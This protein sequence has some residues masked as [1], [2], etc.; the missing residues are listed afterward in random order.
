M[1]HRPGSIPG[2]RTMDKMLNERWPGEASG[3][4]LSSA[5]GR[6]AEPSQWPRLA[7]RNESGDAVSEHTVLRAEEHNGE[8]VMRLH[9]DRTRTWREIAGRVVGST[10]PISGESAGRFDGSIRVVV[11]GQ[12]VA[13]TLA[14]GDREI[15]ASWVLRRMAETRRWF[16]GRSGLERVLGELSPLYQIAESSTEAAA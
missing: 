1:K 7:L 9:G 11:A 5:V 15:V 4:S 6:W 13:V 12:E 3:V 8:M 16:G 10:R 2:A 14:P